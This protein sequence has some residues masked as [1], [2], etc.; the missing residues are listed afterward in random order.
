MKICIYGAG[1]VGGLMGAWLARAGHEVCVVARGATLEAIRRDGLRVR[2]LASGELL[3]TR[4]A[5]E[6][7]PG[8]LGAQDCVIVAVKGQSLREVAD[9]IA[10]LLGPATTI[11]TAM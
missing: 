7:D 10:P 3:V 8:L 11:V 5:A 1:A 9:S 2:T 4:P 6:R